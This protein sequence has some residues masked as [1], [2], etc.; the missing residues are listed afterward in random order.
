[1]STGFDDW[2]ASLWAS[3]SDGS[4]AVLR[5]I[6][7]EHGP[8]SPDQ[9]QR[10]VRDRQLKM[11]RDAFAL[12]AHDIAATTNTE[13]PPFEYKGEAGCIRLAYGR[14]EASMP[15]FGLAQAEVA[16]EVADFM[17]DEVV[18]HLWAVWPEC[19]GHS[20]G[21]HLDVV[22]GRAAWVC[23][24]SGGHVVANVGELSG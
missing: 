19:H 17:R 9:V 5:Q 8:I 4:R 16:I 13:P 14:C 12:V 15:V 2:A 22:D 1:M 11:A 24:A 20:R 3:Q 10:V 23:L 21:M 18:E 7:D 6:F